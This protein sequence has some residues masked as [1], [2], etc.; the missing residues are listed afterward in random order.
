MPPGFMNAMTGRRRGRPGGMTDG[1]ACCASAIRLP[2]GESH[3]R[4]PRSGDHLAG[5]RKRIDVPMTALAI[6]ATRPCRCRSASSGGHRRRRFRREW[7]PDRPVFVTI[8]LTAYAAG[9]TTSLR[10]RVE[11]Q[12]HVGD[13]PAER[14]GAGHSRGCRPGLAR[15]SC[16]PGGCA[17]DDGVDLRVERCA[18]SSASPATPEQSSYAVGSLGHDTLVEQHDDGLDALRSQLRHERVG[19][20]DL[21]GELQV[22][23]RRTG[24]TIVGVSFNVMPM[25]PT[26]MPLTS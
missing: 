5:R 18:M 15:C 6:G 22:R 12:V 7:H 14:R 17:E 10:L 2:S 24:V 20:V 26:L 4:R 1:S 25:K 23:R 9:R 8:L 16:T 3:R 19:G 21:V 11:Q 13:H